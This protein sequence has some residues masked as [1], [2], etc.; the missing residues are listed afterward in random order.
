VTAECTE[1]QG[2]K[3]SMIV[4]RLLCNMCICYMCG[5]ST[6][7]TQRT[8]RPY[9]EVDCQHTTRCVAASAMLCAQQIA[10]QLLS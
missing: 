3:V 6:T 8:R 7:A 2:G 10:W 5:S 4:T 9:L 1:L